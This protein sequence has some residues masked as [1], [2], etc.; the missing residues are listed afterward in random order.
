M[1]PEMKKGTAMKRTLLTACSLLWISCA[2]PAVGA[3]KAPWPKDAEP[4][5][6]AANAEVLQELPF[7]DTED[8]EDAQR[9]FIATL[10]QGTIHGDEGKVVWDLEAY[11]FLSTPD[12]PP[13][14][15]PSL[16]RQARLNMNNGLFEITTNVAGDRGIYQV[17]GFD[18]ASM[19]IVEGETGVIL[20][21]PMSSVETAGAALELYRQ[22]R[23]NRPV[24]A[25]IY[26]HSHVD[27]FGGVRGVVSD[28][29]LQN[30]VKILAPDGFLEHA[31]SEN[32]FAGT[33]MNRRSSYH[34]GF[35]LPRGPRGQVDA[36][37]GKANS[38]GQIS[39][40]APQPENV[41]TKPETEPVEI[42]E[43]DDVQ[44]HFLLAP[45]TEAPAEMLIWFPQFSALCA[46]EDMNHLNHNL[47]TLRGA[48]VRSARNWWKVINQTL[49][50]FGTEAEVM[51]FAHTW[52][53]WGQERIVD[54]MKKQR[55]LYKYVHDQ[56]LHLL[57]Q[58]YTMVEVA[59]L[60]RLPESLA[61]EW[62][63]RDY[64]GTVNHNAKAVYQRYLGWYDSNPANLHPLPPEQSAAK[65]L[66]YMGSSS[67]VI[68]RARQAFKNGE[69]R[70]VAQIMNLVVFAEPDNQAAKELQA[71]A[72]EQLGY[73]AESASWRNNYLTGASELRN[74]VPEVGQTS[75][76]SDTLREMTLDLLFDYWGILL[77]GPRA[78]G[79]TIVLNWDFTDT[80]E[81]YVLTLENSA[82]T[83]SGPDRQSSEADATLRLARTTLDEINLGH[84]TL[85][86]AVGG[87]LVQIT[88]NPA[89]LVE[90]LGLLER[91]EVGFNIVTP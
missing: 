25:V 65:F 70:W 2:T 91:F 49:D 48:Q 74:G 69:Y 32:V 26:T 53:V 39:L 40:V 36:G 46:A 7:W 6:M 34:L 30:G 84:V 87:G 72:L 59:E 5:T 75:G 10:P 56:S 78:D 76:G 1:H 60:I 88:G 57:N 86:Q 85:Q 12:A 71:D 23:G 79:K 50:L 64:Y 35:Y 73:Q 8:F 63:N 13:T 58:G 21:D 66:E 55:D 61:Q 33:A 62:F 47:L 41:I 89:K 19:M 28:D 51:F 14:V 67:A 15:N 17:R 80:G 38:L 45:D 18:L 16:W 9:G 27:H 77:D 4:A 52:P 68:A 20:I 29:D 42:R 81:Q 3:D 37:L 90:L 44:M 11:A 83:Y 54:F 43:V 22:Y 31:V 82:L 24:K